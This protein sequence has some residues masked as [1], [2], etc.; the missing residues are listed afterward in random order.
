M[1]FVLSLGK[2]GD[3]NE[4]FSVSPNDSNSREKPI[5]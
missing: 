2:T 4:Y 3:I 1:S 5:E